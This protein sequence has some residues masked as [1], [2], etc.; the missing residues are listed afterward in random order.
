LGKKT[1]LG[2]PQDIEWAIAGGKV[3][4]LQSRPITTLEEKD[5]VMGN[6]NNSKKWNFLWSS[7]NAGEALP[8]VMTPSTWVLNTRRN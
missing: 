2:C 4:L 3:F 6:W 1:E 7:V 8:E 5:P